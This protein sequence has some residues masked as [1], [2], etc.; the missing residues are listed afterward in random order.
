MSENVRRIRICVNSRANKCVDGFSRRYVF[1]CEMVRERE[2]GRILRDPLSK[3]RVHPLKVERTRT[4][5]ERALIA[6]S[7]RCTDETTRN[8]D[9]EK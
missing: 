2:G 4:R 5:K 9:R 6:E 7:R 8:N 1:A 3:L